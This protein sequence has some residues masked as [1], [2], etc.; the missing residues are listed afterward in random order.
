MWLLASETGILQGTIFR[1]HSRWGVIC[2]VAPE[3]VFQDISAL[4]F[5]GRIRGGLAMWATEA[6]M[7]RSS[8]VVIGDGGDA[9]AIFAV[10]FFLPLG[11]HSAG[12]NSGCC[13]QHLLSEWGD[14]VPWT[15]QLNRPF[16]LLDEVEGD[17]AASAPSARDVLC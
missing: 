3:S 13:A 11:L 4:E 1:I 14:G 6:I 2:E 8:A 12:L 9:S 17:W 15:L 16:V 7:A 10:S 5:E